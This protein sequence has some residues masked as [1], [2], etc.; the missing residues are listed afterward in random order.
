MVGSG[1]ELLAFFN[2]FDFGEL[3]GIVILRHVSEVIGVC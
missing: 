1:Q 2:A 3:Q